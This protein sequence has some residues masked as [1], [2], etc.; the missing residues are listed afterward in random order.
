M[1]R[2]PGP[3]RAVEAYG[4][5]LGASANAGELNHRLYPRDLATAM[6]ADAYAMT[7]P[8][9]RRELRSRAQPDVGNRADLRLRVQDLL[10]VSDADATIACA[11]ARRLHREHV[12]S[13][14]AAYDA[15]RRL[16]QGGDDMREAERE[17][18]AARLLTILTIKKTALSERPHKK[19]YNPSSGH[20]PQQTTYKVKK[21]K[22]D[23]PRR[24]RNII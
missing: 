16:S 13:L 6:L 9:L 10:G 18:S 5:A 22:E 23:E 12:A 14:R 17:R 8:E 2:W 1:D 7:V 4:F 24:S 15:G 19:N 21:A 3:Q 11:T 20:Q